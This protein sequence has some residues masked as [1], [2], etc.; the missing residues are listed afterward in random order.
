MSIRVTLNIRGTCF[1]TYESTL[2]RFPNT[3]LGNPILREPYFNA[4]KD[5]Y[6]FDRS[7]YI[8][9]TILFFY[10]SGGILAKPDYIDEEEFQDELRFFGI[11]KDQSPIN[12]PKTQKLK[13]RQRLWLL[14]EFPKSSI[15][16]KIV[17][18]LSVIMIVISTLT[19][20][21]ETTIEDLFQPAKSKRKPKIIGSLPPDSFWYVLETFYAAWFALEYSLRIVSHPN[22]I[23]FLMSVLG[24]VDL[25]AILPYICLVSGKLDH[26]EA[27]TRTMRFL[28]IFR[29]LKFSRYSKTLQL[30]GKSLYYCKGQIS[31]LLVFFFINC[32]ACGSILYWVERTMLPKPS[33]SLMDTMW[34]CIISMTT[35]GYGDI[36]PQTSL[37]KLVCAVTILVGIVV[38]FHIFIPVYLSYFALLYEISILQSLEKS[39]NEKQPESKQEEDMKRH[40]R[41]S[42][43]SSVRKSRASVVINGMNRSPSVTARESISPGRKP[44]VCA[45]DEVMRKMKYD[46][47]RR[48]SSSESPLTASQ[49]S[50]EQNS[51]DAPFLSRKGS[52]LRSFF[53]T[54]SELAETDDYAS[55]F[56]ETVTEQRRPKPALKGRRK[57]VFEQPQIQPEAIQDYERLIAN[58]DKRSVSFSDERSKEGSVGSTAD[59]FGLQR[60]RASSMHGFGL[61]RQGE[62]VKED[63][64]LEYL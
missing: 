2:Q 60:R 32:L 15:F 34:L 47:I 4:E 5:E 10:Q 12:L 20:C 57:A 58:R 30:L 55:V 13:L 49:K 61:T 41:M 46:Y 48:L 17:A 43:S 63:H 45:K 56:L 50:L 3:L 9:D 59:S 11:L 39:E 16:A 7:Q 64:E 52:L 28:Q 19:Y 51:F 8:F 22:K 35:V 26:S 37:G 44:S 1:E 33:A 14:L 27:A 38:L 62:I 31:L 6:C 36:V 54:P 53:D 18:R 21:M 23:S 25:L 29:I 40:R 24:F 42:I